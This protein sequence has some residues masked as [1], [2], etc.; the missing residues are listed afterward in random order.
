MKSK[1]VNTTDFHVKRLPT[2]TNFGTA[3]IFA[4]ICVCFFFLIQISLCVHKIQFDRGI[5]NKWNVFL[6]SFE[7]PNKYRNLQRISKL[8]LFLIL[9]N[10]KCPF[11]VNTYESICCLKILSECPKEQKVSKKSQ[12]EPCF[13]SQ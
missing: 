11:N 8:C 4:V 5:F 2:Y 10:L 3:R 13:F 1:H 9:S 7:K 6:G 12:K